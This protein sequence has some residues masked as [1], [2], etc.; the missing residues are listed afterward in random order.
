MQRD[1]ER[2]NHYPVAI[3][4]VFINEKK[5]TYA[6]II[7]G[8]KTKQAAHAL[9]VSLKRAGY[10]SLLKNLSNKQRLFKMMPYPAVEETN[11]SSAYQKLAMAK[12]D[13]EYLLSNE[14][15]MPTSPEFVQ[16][17]MYDLSLRDAIL[18]SLRYSSDLQTTE[19]DRV[20]ARYQLRLSENEFE[21]QYALSAGSHFSWSKNLGIRQPFQNSYDASPSV[22]LKSSWGGTGKVTMNNTYDGTDYSPQM[23]LNL[24]QPLLRGTGPSVV[25]SSLRDKLDQEQS[26]K[27]SLKDSYINKVTSVISAYRDLISQQN[28][29]AT[30][31][32]SLKYARYTY[33]VNKKRIEAGELEPAGNIQQ[34]YQVA[35]LSLTL[36]SQ[37][38][39]LKQSKRSLLQL[40]GLDPSLRIH[41]P[42]NIQVSNMRAPSIKKSVQYAFTH[43]VS[44]LNALISYRMTKRAL[45]NAQNQQLWELNLTATHTYGSAAAFGQGKGFTNIT[46][47]RNQASQVGLRLNVPINDLS[48]KSSLISAKVSLEKARLSLLAQKRQLETDVINKV[49]NIKTQINLYRMHIK[50][51]SLAKRSYEIE[52]KKRKVGISSSLDVTN[53]QNQLID[54]RN[55]LIASKIS[56]LEG[57]SS[58]EQLLATTLDMWNIKMG[59]I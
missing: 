12:N 39:Q 49:V 54:A 58:L 13:P 27:L 48:R 40:I 15:N 29:Y 5:V 59:F 1:I 22:S 30:Q 20:T 33:W 21:L 32:K 53:T 11:V 55:S 41:V 9:Q 46:N 7:E 24:E 19:L 31:S 17:T 26:N 50:Q 2:F 8:F 6:L 14:L 44:Y 45:V 43:N 16:K 57:V 42:N 36:E 28:S 56:Y 25:E 3:K 4:Q 10:V 51:Q 47:G 52:V 38:N 35:N 37:S 34:E 18:L 23:V